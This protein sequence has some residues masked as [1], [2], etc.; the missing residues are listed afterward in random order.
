M[1]ERLIIETQR[2]KIMPFSEE[3][4]TEEYVRW[5]NDPEVVRYS[6]QRHH[7]HSLESCREYW[8][9]FIDSPH[10]FWAILKTGNEPEH[11][12]N[13]NAYIDENNLVADIGIL[14]GKK[15]VWGK[16]YGFE[17]WNAVCD[18]LFKVVRVRKIT[19]GTM[20]INHGMIRLMEKSG[21]IEDGVHSRQLLYV[22][23]EI[24]VVCK[25]FFQSLPLKTKD[26]RA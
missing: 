4:L 7:R 6:E 3:H 11:I 19:A 24:D 25:A 26:N 17:A 18:Y 15:S 21:M 8:K 12:G 23:D 13:I 16:G 14:I 22:S 9:S 5:L 2:L 1:N 20:A 10:F